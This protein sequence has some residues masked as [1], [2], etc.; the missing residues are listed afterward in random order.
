METQQKQPAIVPLLLE[1]YLHMAKASVDSPIFRNFYCLVDDEKQ[2]I[3][4]DGDLSCAFFVSWILIP[5]KLLK[6]SHATVS[7][8]IK[9]LANSGWT[10]IE[11]P[12]PGA[13]LVW[14][15]QQSGEEIHAHV[16]FYLGDELAVSNDYKKRSPQIHPWNS[17][18]IEEILWHP[19]L[20]A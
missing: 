3:L 18:P 7:G 14:T 6:E 9:D 11:T 16:G 19:K 12:K 5:F 4:R 20:D 15:P 17:R 10:K 13:V 8:T 1:N 2:D